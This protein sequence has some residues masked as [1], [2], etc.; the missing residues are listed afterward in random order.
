MT[1]IRENVPDYTY[2]SYFA[3]VLA[4]KVESYHKNKGRTNVRAWVE[5]DENSLGKTYY[6]VRSNLKMKVPQTVEELKESVYL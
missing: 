4:K 6:M 2:S 3:N 1:M 5:K